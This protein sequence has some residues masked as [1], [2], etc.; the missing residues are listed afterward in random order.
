MGSIAIQNFL[1]VCIYSLL[2]L[3]GNTATAADKPKKLEY[4]HVKITGWDVH[5]ETKLAKDPRTRI[6]LQYIE[7]SLKQAKIELPRKHLDKLQKVPIWISENNG[8]DVEYYFYERR[9]YQGGFDPK[10]FGGIEIQNIDNF[11]TMIEYDKGIMVHELAHAYHNM[12]YK[13]IDKLIMKAFKNAGWERLYKKEETRRDRKPQRVYASYSP[14]EY[15]AE[16]SA[17]Y[18]VGNHYYPYDYLDLKK[19]DPM[20]YEMI[21]E[22]WK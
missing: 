17:I 11:L 6:V 16:L 4:N 8:K 5:I 12:N 15:F 2:I 3:I 14:F 19:H 21:L 20:G 9:V 1:K 18:F 22:A 10:K 7:K 13:K